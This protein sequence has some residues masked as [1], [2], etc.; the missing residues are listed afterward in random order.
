MDGDGYDLWP[1]NPSASGHSNGAP[2]RAGF[3]D[4]DLNSQA[5]D[6]FPNLDEYGAFLQGDDDQLVGRGRGSGLPPPFALR[7]RLV[8][9]TSVPDVVLDGPVE[10]HRAP[11]NSTLVIHPRRHLVAGETAS[12]RRRVQLPLAASAPTQPPRHLSPI[13]LV[14]VLPAPTPRSVEAAANADVGVVPL[15][16][17]MLA[18]TSA[19]PASPST[20]TMNFLMMWRN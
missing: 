7:A 19:V 14:A 16:Q 11:V 18:S 13:H 4:F 15:H 6:G 3:E 12:C 17:G 2:F 8:C 9:R 1:S 5:A 10:R 20:T